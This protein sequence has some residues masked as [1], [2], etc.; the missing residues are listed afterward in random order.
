[1]RLGLFG[2]ESGIIAREGNLEFGAK[3]LTKLIGEFTW[4]TL[5]NISV[6]REWKSDLQRLEGIS[7]FVRWV[8]R[9]F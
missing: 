7:A 2:G 3:K 1:M 6:I 5:L 8:Y 9:F 4:I